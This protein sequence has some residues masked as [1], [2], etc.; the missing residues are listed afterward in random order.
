TVQSELLQL[1]PRTLLDDRTD[2]PHAPA[3]P[4]NA[5]QPSRSCPT[6]VAIHDDGNMAGQTGPFEPPLLEF[7]VGIGIVGGQLKSN[8]AQ[9]ERGPRPLLQIPP[10]GQS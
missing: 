4:F 2:A 5:R 10:S 3:M 1:H 6:A 7:I 8:P 9:T